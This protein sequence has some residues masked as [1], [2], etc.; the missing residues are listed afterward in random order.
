[1]VDIV[2]ND[3]N[4]NKINKN[5]K[6]ENI[7]KKRIS[8]SVKKNNIPNIFGVGYLTAQSGSMTGTFEKGDNIWV[9]IANEKRINNLQ[10][11]DIITFYD[12]T[13]AESIS[14]TGGEDDGTYLNTH[15]IVDIV[16]N[17]NG[18]KTYICQGDYVKKTFPG[19][20]YSKDNPN[21]AYLQFVIKDDIKAV[22]IKNMGKGMTG[23]LKFARSSLGFGLCIVL[24]TALLLVYEVVM[25]IRNIFTLNKE[26]MEAKMAEDKA[27]AQEDLEAQKQRMREELL[28]ELKAEQAKANEAKEEQV[29]EQT[30]EEVKEPEEVKEEENK[31]E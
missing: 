19:A 3:K 13:I 25:L 21:N 14:Q 30:S 2:E 29:E 10:V 22:Y 31:E 28:A 9:H 27:L 12:A 1:M 17:A 15:R 20:V 16:E 6:N 4:K 8:N 26:K 23:L 11:G 5:Q 18:T 7:N 24:P